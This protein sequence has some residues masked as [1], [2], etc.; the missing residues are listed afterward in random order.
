S[1]GDGGN[2]IAVDAAGYAYVTGG[3][4]SADF[5]TTTGAF[6]TTSSG[7]G[8]GSDP[9]A[10][11][12]KLNPAGSALIY[13]TYFGGSGGEWGNWIAVDSQG[14]AYVTGATSSIDFPTTA[15]SFQPVF[16]G[17][18]DAFVTKLNPTGSALVYSTYLGGTST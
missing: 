2:A 18:A 5:P 13:S 17:V 12:T 4:R 16:G 8:S 3:T 14:N 7:S 11:V 10:F 1:G 9:D 6:Q 15:G